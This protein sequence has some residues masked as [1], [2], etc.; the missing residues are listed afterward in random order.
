MDGGNGAWGGKVECVGGGVKYL[1]VC[2][3]KGAWVVEE[4][5]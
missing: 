2:G 5:G 4:G 3:G 1:A